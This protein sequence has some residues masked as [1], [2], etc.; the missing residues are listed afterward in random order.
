MGKL[1]EKVFSIGFSWSIE[2]IIGDLLANLEGGSGALVI[3]RLL[4]FAGLE[5][6]GGG[7]LIG[8]NVLTS[9]YY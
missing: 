5:V 8:S 2:F 4:S 3:E 9:F 1:G 7:A 6:I